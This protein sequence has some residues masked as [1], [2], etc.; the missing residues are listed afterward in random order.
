MVV[1]KV[2]DRFLHPLALLEQHRA[3][4]VHVDARHRRSFLPRAGAVAE[5]RRRSISAGPRAASSTILSRPPWPET[6]VTASRGT[7]STSASSR[8]TASFARPCSG[9]SVT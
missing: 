3:E 2:R 1:A 8:S 5:E 4:L 9:G 6:R 7:D